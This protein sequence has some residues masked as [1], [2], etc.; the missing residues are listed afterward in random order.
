MK[1]VS[2][3]EHVVVFYAVAAFVVVHLEKV[4]ASKSEESEATADGE[5]DDC[6][7]NRLSCVSLVVSPP[8][9][10]P[11]E[12]PNGSY[13]N[14]CA[15][16]LFSTHAESSTDIT[17][18]NDSADVDSESLKSINA[19]I[20][21]DLCESENYIEH[22][23]WHTIAA[24]LENTIGALGRLSRD[25]DLDDL[26]NG[27][28]IIYLRGNGESFFEELESIRTTVLFVLQKT[29]QFIKSHGCH[30]M[31]FAFWCLGVFASLD[32]YQNSPTLAYTFKSVGNMILRYTIH[33]V[34]YKEIFDVRIG[35]DADDGMLKVNFIGFVL[36]LEIVSLSANS[37]RTVSFSV[38][39]FDIMSIFMFLGMLVVINML[40]SEHQSQATIAHLHRARK[41]LIL[42]RYST[43]FMR[44]P[45]S[46]QLQSIESC[47][48][49]LQNLDVNTLP[50]LS[51]PCRH[52]FH[53]ACLLMWVQQKA[54]NTCPYCRD[55]F[56]TDEYTWPE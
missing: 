47:V 17:G 31:L 19:G 35:R 20:D 10:P 21:L 9:L 52:D 26:D 45:M 43:V 2:F 56:F 44:P 40:F 51:L 42:R 14:P 4:A 7:A 6:I 25:D 33:L 41:L 13:T 38:T 16:H 28:E 48:I 46:E 15:I 12:I 36:G 3:F 1:S 54:G 39:P 8:E 11:T 30:G 22:E 5:S 32:I 37:M 24:R 49:C 27:T 18:G 34:L 53:R 23:R 29:L 50:V 55:V